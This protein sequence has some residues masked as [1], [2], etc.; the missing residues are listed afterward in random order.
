MK[1]ESTFADTHLIPSW[2]RPEWERQQRPWSC[3]T[4]DGTLSALRTPSGTQ[5]LSIVVNTAG[6]PLSAQSAVHAPITRSLQDHGAIGYI[7]TRAEGDLINLSFSFIWKQL[8]PRWTILLRVT[9]SRL[10][11]WHAYVTWQENNVV[12]YYYYYYIIKYYYR[13]NEFNR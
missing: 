11:R 7:Y 12:N 5:P 3:G 6:W 4:A 9:N 10:R 8:Q 2:A 13:N 1:N